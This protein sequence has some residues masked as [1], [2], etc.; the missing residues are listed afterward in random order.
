MLS[1]LEVVNLGIVRHASLEL[2]PGLIALTGETGAGKTVLVTAI[3][4]LLGER[5]RAELVGTAGDRARVRAIVDLD[6]SEVLVERELTQEGRTRCRVDGELVSVAELQ[7][8]SARALQLVGQHESVF[9]TRPETQ[10]EILDRLGGTDE[11]EVSAA[12]S[13]VIRL[14]QALRELD[15]ALV[16]QAREEAL[17]Q[18]ELAELDAAELRS[19]TEDVELEAHIERLTHAEEL[20]EVLAGLHRTLRGQG[21]M[22][23]QVA[24]AARHLGA[25]EP[26]LARRLEALVAEAI[27]V[28]DDVRRAFEALEVDRAS[29]ERA[30]V[31]FGLLAQLKR[32]FGPTLGAVIEA[33]EERAARLGALAS[34]RD[35]RALVE[36]ELNAA[37]ERLRAAQDALRAQRESTRERLLGHVGAALEELG[38][39][40]A[41]FDV[42]LG[43]PEGTPTFVFRSSRELPFV[44]LG[45]GVSGGELSRIVLALAE[46]LGHGTE[47]LVLDEIDAGLGG[48]AALG[49]ARRL[50]RLARERQVVVVTH[51]ASI[52][53]AA[54]AHF[55]VERSVGD[56]V[57]GGPTIVQVSG[58]AR[59]REV[60]RL[61]SGQPDADEALTH[62]RSL[63][64]RYSLAEEG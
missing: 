30:E 24:S 49:V 48:R 52:A 16:A 26:E 27:D 60:A 7:R 11:S 5:P 4:L 12:R 29:L 15:E 55:V 28:S 50:V 18:H 62:A 64:A 46:L 25:G 59:V 43:G 53:A 13:E 34:R 1:A 32:R 37:R 56:G 19:P 14:E 22:V 17:L 20:K 47:T 2:P 39:E 10:R 61:L 31:R 6:G 63:L 58:D 21:G 36:T 57:G 9:V 44:E 51:T 40:G 41:Q 35:D 33:R 3:G 23:D 45:R 38:L 8:L 42:R 54:D